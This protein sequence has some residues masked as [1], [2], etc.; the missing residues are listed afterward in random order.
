ML[1]QQIT[2]V[3]FKLPE[4]YERMVEFVANNSMDEWKKHEDTIYTTFVKHTC[5]TITLRG[6]ENGHDKQTGGN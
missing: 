6:G 1:I 4:E 3:G 2:S 5:N